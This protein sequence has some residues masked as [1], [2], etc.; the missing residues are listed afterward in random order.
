MGGVL[1]QI[2]D[3]DRE[4][5]DHARWEGVSEAKRESLV[6]AVVSFTAERS[7]TSSAIEVATS[8]ILETQYQGL[9]GK[10]LLNV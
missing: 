3:E 1:K 2:A 4:A 10:M 5:V 7:F 6:W 8:L 9:I